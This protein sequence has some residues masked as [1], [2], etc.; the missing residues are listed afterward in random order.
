M[1]EYEI[2]ILRADGRAAIITY[3]IQL[4]DNAAIR[5]ALKIANG[6]KVEIW[7]GTDCIYGTGPVPAAVE[8]SP[9][10]PAA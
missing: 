5:S 2:R 8:P 3:E 9:S 7:R 4:N 6:R 1:G 10:S